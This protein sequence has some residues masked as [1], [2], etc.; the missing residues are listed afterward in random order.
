MK[1]TLLLFILI[2]VMVGAIGCIDS[3]SDKASPNDKVS[4]ED[5][6]RGYFNAVQDLN[7]EK[8]ASYCTEKFAETLNLENVM[9]RNKGKAWKFSITSIEV[10][11]QGENDAEVYVNYDYEF[12]EEG[13]VVHG[14]TP[15]T[16][17]LIKVENSWL[18]NEAW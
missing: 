6:I 9:E 8:I 14:Y 1:K 13:G 18:I 10:F 15:V 17:F 11:E 2:L 3:R 7:E 4:P 5:T 12:N 16:F